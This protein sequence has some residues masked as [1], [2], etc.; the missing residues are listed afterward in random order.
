MKKSNTLDTLDK[1]PIFLYDG[2]DYGEYHTLGQYS[3]GL[4]Q[5]EM[6]KSYEFDSDLYERILVHERLHAVSGGTYRS[7]TDE[8]SSFRTR[9]GFSQDLHPDKND[10]IAATNVALNEAITEHLTRAII[11]GEWEALNPLDRGN[12]IHDYSYL[13]ERILLDDLI[14][15]SYGI[16]DLRT[17]TKAYFED[18]ETGAELKH[19][20]AMIREFRTAY[21]DGTLRK[22]QKLCELNNRSTSCADSEF[23]KMIH[24][25]TLDENGNVIKK[26]YIKLTTPKGFND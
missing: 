9:T 13:T 20:R 26:G 23:K 5:I 24:T 6:L 1:T 4:N 14:K 19:R 12:Y 18:T 8:L 7:D 2:I 17:I 15:K 21:E 22:F 25:P 16:I 11:E 10:N 3:P